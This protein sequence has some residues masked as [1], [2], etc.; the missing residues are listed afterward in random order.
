MQILNV[1]LEKDESILCEPGTMAYMSNDVVGSVD[2]G[3]CCKRMMGGN[4]CIMSVY[5]AGSGDEFIGITP[6]LPA[7]V[8]P[9]DLATVSSSH[10]RC[11]SGTFLASIGKVNLDFSLDCC[12]CTCCFGGQGCVRQ[13]I[14]GTGTAFLSA[15]G[16]VIEKTLEQGETLVV[17]TNSLVAWESS[18]KLGLKSTGCCSCACCCGGEGLFNTTLSGPGKVYIQSYSREKFAAAIQSLMPPQN[19]DGPGEEGGAPAVADEME[20]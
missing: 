19:K 13:S 17:D 1:K 9:L 2:C 18:V 8:I 16:T 15:M 11:K 12:S 3:N 5:T 20:R 7:K 4:P 6:N 14:G 10:M